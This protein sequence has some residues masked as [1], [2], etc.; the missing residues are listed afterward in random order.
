MLIVCEGGAYARRALCHFWISLTLLSDC[1]S[2]PPAGSSVLFASQPSCSFFPHRSASRVAM[3]LCFLTN[4]DSF[5]CCTAF[6]PRLRQMEQRDGESEFLAAHSLES[7]S[8]HDTKMTL[9]VLMG[10]MEIKNVTNLL[11]GDDT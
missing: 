10:S 9:F 11:A 2:V 4:K 8:I 3:E 1:L 7:E 5:H 6:S